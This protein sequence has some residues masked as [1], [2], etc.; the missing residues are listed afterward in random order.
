M[1][2]KTSSVRIEISYTI[3]LGFDNIDWS[4]SNA[5]KMSGWLNFQTT[6]A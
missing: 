2:T 4:D 3:F 1:L 5:G 6:R